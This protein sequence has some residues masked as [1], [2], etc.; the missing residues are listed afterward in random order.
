MNQILKNID[1]CQ[2]EAGSSSVPSRSGPCPPTHC[3]RTPPPPMV[4]GAEK[5]AIVE[6]RASVCGLGQPSAETLR[7]CG[8][9]GRELRS[10]AKD[11]G[12]SEELE[13]QHTTA[14]RTRRGQT[15]ACA[16][17]PPGGAIPTS[18]GHQTHAA[19]SSTGQRGATRGSGW[20]GINQCIPA[21]A[22]LTGGLGK[23]KI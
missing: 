5:S 14:R 13:N 22:L 9:S 11:G 6:R 12:P 2:S 15:C 1:Q 21:W 23:A 4:I 20:L 17:P 16:W 8:V 3:P 18:I 7:A 10:A 19:S